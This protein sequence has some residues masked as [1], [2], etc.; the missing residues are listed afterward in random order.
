MVRDPII[1]WIG[2]GAPGW[3][4]LASWIGSWAVWTSAILVALAF[5]D[6]P[7]RWDLALGVAVFMLVLL[8]LAVAIPVLAVT[9]V[10]ALAGRQLAMR[11]GEVMVAAALGIVALAVIWTLQLH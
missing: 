4:A 5:A 7:W 3:L 11:V 9:A 2:E 1:D 10:I 8:L 6:E